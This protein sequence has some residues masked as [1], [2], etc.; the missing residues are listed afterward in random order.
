MRK[1]DTYSPHR[2]DNV[3]EEN[4]G[5]EEDCVFEAAI[6][7]S[8]NVEYCT[9]K[10]EQVTPIQGEGRRSATGQGMLSNPSTAIVVYQKMPWIL[11]PDSE[12]RLGEREPVDIVMSNQTEQYA[13]SFPEDQIGESYAVFLEDETDE[14]SPKGRGQKKMR[15]G[16]LFAYSIDQSLKEGEF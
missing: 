9:Y 3:S 1:F 6:K 16:K 7:N 4:K 13:E 15:K 10:E 2:K 8:V 12:H 14:E 11:I 5:R